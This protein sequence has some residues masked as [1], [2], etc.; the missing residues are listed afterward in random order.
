MAALLMG[1]GSDSTGPSY[2]APVLLMVNGVTKATG[3]VGM[4]VIL[5]GRELGEARL[6]NVYFLASDGGELQAAT[7]DWANEYIVATV[8]QGTATE[9]K[10]WVQT[11]SGVTDTLDF[12]LI[13][14]QTFS[15]SNINWTRTTDLPQALQG[16]DA[17]FVPVEHGS[18]RT[19]Y[20]FTVG[21]AA[22]GTN[23]AT[24]AVFR[25]AV[26]ESGA[27]S[28]WDASV[29]QLPSERAYHAVAVATP[30]TAPLD[31]TTAAH[32]YA[33][34]GIDAAGAAL[35]SVVYGTVGLDGNLGTWRN[36]SDL[37]APLHS[38]RA[39]VYRGYLYV[40]GGATGENTPVSDAYRAPVRADGTLGAWQ[41]IPGLPKAT[42]H[43]GL[44]NFGPYLYVVGG[45]TAVVA[46]ANSG[47]SG[48]ETAAGYMA[49]IDM[50]DGTVPGWTAVSTPAKARG[51][52]GMMSAGGSVVVTSGMYSGQVGSSENSYATIGPDGTLSSWGGATGSSIIQLVLGY[53]IF[54]QAAISF[55]DGEGTGHVVVLGGG[56]RG[57]A[58]G[59]SAGVVYY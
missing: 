19:K 58:G 7:T 44:V 6:G 3:L 15:P 16:L 30:Y 35:S 23:V 9:S 29:T 5:E 38:A 31:T 13:N 40:V 55:V 36:G 8:P 2:G 21:G 50:R 11:R 51:K 22:D 28:A 32:I 37:P 39:R 57:S 24:G 56:I 41:P 17:V 34:G 4:T 27:I 10:V 49:R 45:D 26:Q 46:P 1:C 54:N 52:H 53:G 43:H 48:T 18:A 47:T 20:I 33:I 12:T 59:A 14:G 25:G 42:A